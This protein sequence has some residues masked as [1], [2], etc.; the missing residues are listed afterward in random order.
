MLKTSFESKKRPFL[1]VP[2]SVYILFSSRYVLPVDKRGIVK[3]ENDVHL[4][5]DVLPPYD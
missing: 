4:K 1:D 2:V 5:K 3:E